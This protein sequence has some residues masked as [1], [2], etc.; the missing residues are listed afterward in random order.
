MGSRKFQKS[1]DTVDQ[2][3]LESFTNQ[4]YEVR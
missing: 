4:K 3:L 1:S 2:L